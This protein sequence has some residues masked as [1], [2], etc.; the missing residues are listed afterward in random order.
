M[1]RIIVIAILILIS[2]L[3]ETTVFD[4]HDL[5]GFSPDLL[6][7]L[8]MSFGIMR[9]R[10]EGMLTGFFSG[11]LLDVFFSP[12]MGG[13]MLLYMF[14]GYINGFFHKNYMMKDVMLPIFISAVDTFVVRF[15][16]YVTGFLLRNRTEF[17]YY[18]IHRML[19]QMIAAMVATAVIYR[20]Y[21]LINAWLKKSALKKRRKD[22]A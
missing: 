4:Y 2:F 13:Y 3:L 10:R 18:F 5:T 11:F 12:Y 1:K 8:T 20:G 6:L 21:V 19:P 15:V 16:V 22:L 17:K 7:I 14:V 9:G